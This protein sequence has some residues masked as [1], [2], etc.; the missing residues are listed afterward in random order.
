VAT[1]GAESRTLNKDIA[2]RLTAFGRKVLRIMFRRINVNKNWRKLHH[3]YLMQ[4]LFGVYF[5]LFKPIG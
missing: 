2:K 1:Y 3:T 5:H 4:L